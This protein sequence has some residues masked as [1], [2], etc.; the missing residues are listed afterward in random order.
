M[1]TAISSNR[2]IERGPRTSRIRQTIACRVS[3]ALKTA[4]A[5]RPI[6]VMC[7]SK[8][9]LRKIPRDQGKLT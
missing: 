1:T 9:L 6:S 5:D 3:S 8:P 4:N 7:P 2:A